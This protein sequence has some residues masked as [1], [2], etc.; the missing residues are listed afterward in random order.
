M[1]MN[2]SFL[3]EE[4]NKITD[5][6]INV[7]EAEGK[8][9][10]ETKVVTYP[11]ATKTP[12]RKPYEYKGVKNQTIFPEFIKLCKLSQL[13]LK[14]ILPYRLLESGYTD[15]VIEDGYIYAKGDVPVL[16]VAHLD[17]V[18]DE[19]VKDFYEFVDENEEHVISSP[20]GIGGDDRCGV[21]MILEIIKEHKC[22]VLFCEDE[23]IGTVGA[24]K[25]AKTEFINELS[26]L[27]YL[28]EL[29]RRGW[30]DAV[31][32]DC[33]N[34]KFTKFI[35]D[36]TG[37]EK[38]HGSFTD[39]SIIAPACGVAAV[40][41]SCGYYSA[42]TLEESVN[43]EDMFNTIQVV[44][45][46]IP[47]ECEQFEYIKKTYS[48]G[49]YGYSS[50]GHGYGGY[51]YNRSYYWDDYDDDDYGYYPKTKPESASS[52]KVETEPVEDIQGYVLFVTW[53]KD[54]MTEVAEVEAYGSTEEEAWFNFFRENPET[55]WNDILDYEVDH[56]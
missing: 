33:D 28:I 10:V 41:L 15:V 35:L 16:L 56:F 46:L 43:M 45:N 24:K 31:F 49:G 36:N 17:T 47:V 40:N 42:H 9:T 50:Y 19:T 30:N 6:E 8:E 7:E 23:E 39:I 53:W 12:V 13:G 18:H 5:S 52:D 22:S 4:H 44:K 27:N 1:F 34:A 38:A 55:C 54:D 51:G 20:Q 29:D 48:Y 26:N 25:F 32:Y 37:Y 2:D 3:K 21:Y 14:T 11:L